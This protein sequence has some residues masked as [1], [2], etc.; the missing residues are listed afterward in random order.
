M[1]K[2]YELTDDTIEHDG[3]TL[4]RIRALVDIPAIGVSAGDLGG[5]VE[6]EKNLSH[7][8]DCWV[9]GNARVRGN[10]FVNDN[11]FVGSNMIVNQ[12]IYGEVQ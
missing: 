5:Y 3:R 12:V 9:H 2:K 6:S 8:G 10:A 4:Y 7:T 1:S 11:G